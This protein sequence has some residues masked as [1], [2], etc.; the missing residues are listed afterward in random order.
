MALTY[1]WRRRPLNQDGALSAT[2]RTSFSSEILQAPF[3]LERVIIHWSAW[4]QFTE[5]LPPSPPA[6]GHVHAGLMIWN[7]AG[8][9]PDTDPAQSPTADW[10]YVQM[11]E[12]S[13]R[14]RSGYTGVGFD[15]GFFFSRPGWDVRTR[16]T[17]T[18]TG[19][20]RVSAFLGPLPPD[21]GGGRNYEQQ[22]YI[23]VLL[24]V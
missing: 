8:G 12:G 5:G 15:Y 14:Y 2:N 13:T 24:S 10:L 1:L 19:Q 11:C 20:Y 23:S 7:T 17:V 9:N 21:G 6:G 4:Q 18:G 3:T 16:R 22:A